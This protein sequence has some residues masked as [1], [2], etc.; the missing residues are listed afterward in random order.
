[1]ANRADALKRVLSVLD[2]FEIPYLVGGSLA[3]SVYGLI[4]STLD[5][6][7]VADIKPDQVDEFAD[8]LKADFYADPGMMR[9]AIRH[10][11]S[12]NLIHLPSSFKVDIFP[13]RDDAYSRAQFARRSFRNLV[14]LDESI[15]CSVA[16]AEDTILSKLRWFRLGNEVPQQQWNDLRGIMK[17]SGSRIDLAYLHEWAPKLKIADLLE[18]LLNEPRSGAGGHLYVFVH[19][20][21]T[22]GVLLELIQE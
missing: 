2:Q 1:M 22:G 20:S 17:V 7:L 18:R 21:S 8:A 6:D 13:L 11:R 3:S 14:A 12:F 15:E 16:T 9:E 5:A 19:P 10:G 4:R